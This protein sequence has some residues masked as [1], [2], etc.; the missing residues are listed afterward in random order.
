MWTKIV[1]YLTIKIMMVIFSI[2]LF[3]KTIKKEG[4][5]IYMSDSEGSCTKGQDAK[6]KQN[7]GSGTLTLA[8]NSMKFY[9]PVINTLF[10]FI[11]QH[12]L[13]YCFPI[14]RL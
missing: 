13:G 2:F 5:T 6:I 3:F 8:S 4:S 14:V 9:L 12:Q 11:K 1:S 7:D 10:L